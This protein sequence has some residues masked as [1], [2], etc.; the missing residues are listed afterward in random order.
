MEQLAE[1][2]QLCR[3]D[4]TFELIKYIL[5]VFTAFYS[6]VIVRSICKLYRYTHFSPLPSIQATSETTYFLFMT[7]CV[8]HVLV[9][10]RVKIENR[11]PSLI[12]HVNPNFIVDGNS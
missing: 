2:L 4:C 8:E 1:F 9:Q 10:L 11:Y 6:W 5:D 7:F 3:P 12:V